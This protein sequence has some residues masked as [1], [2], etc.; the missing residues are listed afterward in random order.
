MARNEVG[1]VAGI[2]AALAILFII[3]AL[4][5][6]GSRSSALSTKPLGRV[7]PLLDHPIALA[8]LYLYRFRPGKVGE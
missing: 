8:G 4:A 1:P 2:S 7:H 6:L 5:G 3:I